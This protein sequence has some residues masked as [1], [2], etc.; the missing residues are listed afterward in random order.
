MDIFASIFGALLIIFVI[1]L[2]VSGV[3]LLG[4]KE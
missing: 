1:A 2:T 4:G 3:Y